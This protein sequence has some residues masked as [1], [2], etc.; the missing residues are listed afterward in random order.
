MS[1]A[2]K[3]QQDGTIKLALTDEQRSKLQKVGVWLLEPELTEDAYSLTD[4]AK[5]CDISPAWLR[6]LL[7]DGKIEAFKNDRDHWRVRAAEV[8]RVWQEELQKHLDRLDPEGKKKKYTNRRPTEW[9]VYLMR[10]A[11]G[12]DKTLSQA[13][14]KV[15]LTAV[16]RYEKRWNERYQKRKAKIEAN[17]KENG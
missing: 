8:A 16:D 17:K 7:Q 13:D 3:K 5:I 14:R 2:E 12:K 10:K 15:I 9:A 11:V 4:V 6:R 1:Q